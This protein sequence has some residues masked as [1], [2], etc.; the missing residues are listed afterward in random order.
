[1]LD[2]CAR[3]VLERFGLDPAALEMPPLSRRRKRAVWRVGGYALK[4]FAYEAQAAKVL[5]LSQHL[6]ARGVALPV[7][8]EPGLVQADCGWFLLFP[9]VAGRQPRY[10]EPG[11]TDALAAALAQFHQASA[12]YQ[13]PMDTW[14]LDWDR[15]LSDRR[16]ELHKAAAVAAS[17]DDEF[18]RRFTQAV[19][20][21]RERIRWCQKRLPAAGAHRLSEVARANPL[22]G[23][24]DYSRLNVIETA[25]GGLTIIDLDQ[26]SVSLPVR[27]L[28][29]LVTW[30]NHDLQNWSGERLRQ[31]VWAYGGLTAAEFD[32][33][34][35]DQAMPHLA[36]DIARD[37]YNSARSSHL[38]ELERCLTTDRDRLADLGLGPAPLRD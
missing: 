30:I 5:G 8:A 3:G 34:C 27:D 17:S 18:S 38:E 31:I 23:H 25:G 22:I 24:G 21:L 16:H 11:V 35:L 9:W 4:W 14:M 36:L 37:Y 28:S 6:G 13:G 33:L 10:D 15:L 32:L 26:A 20:W 19:P 29:R 1:M 12:G 7:P 2:D